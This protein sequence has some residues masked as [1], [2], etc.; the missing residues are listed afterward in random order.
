MTAFQLI[1]FLDP[2]ATVGSGDALLLGLFKI[3]LIM[4]GLLYVAFAAIAIR[5]V[6]IM[7]STLI[8]RFSSFVQIASFVHFALAILVLISYFMLL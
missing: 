4:G 7:R 5:Q 6:H 3:M 1:G 8:T 2:T